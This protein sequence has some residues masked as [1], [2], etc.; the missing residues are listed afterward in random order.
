MEERN[1]VFAE[2]EVQVA[3]NGK[4]PTHTPSLVLGI[5][6]IVGGFIM[7]LIGYVCGIIGI[8]LS[9]KNKVAYSTKSGKIC[10]IVG[11]VVAAAMHIL[12]IIMMGAAL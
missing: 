6:A 12:N 10:S 9:S 8:I 1:D 5:V 11:I 3:E 4:K 7:P 2:N